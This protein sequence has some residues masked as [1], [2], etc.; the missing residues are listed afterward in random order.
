MCCDIYS[1][2]FTFAMKVA[3][4]DSLIEKNQCGQ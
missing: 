3:T 4:I 1:L 2:Y